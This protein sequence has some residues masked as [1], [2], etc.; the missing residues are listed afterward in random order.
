MDTLK[1]FTDA[2]KID[3]YKR[4]SNR[5][6]MVSVVGANSVQR[7]GDERLPKD[8]WLAILFEFVYFYVAHAEAGART[9]AGDE[10]AA[11]MIKGLGEPLIHGA[12][13]FVYD[14]VSKDGNRGLKSQHMGELVKRL[15][16]YRKCEHVMPEREGDESKGTALWAL[17]RNVAAL[18]NRPDDVTC[19]MTAHAHVFDSLT[20][21]DT[22]TFLMFT[23]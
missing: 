7:S 10:H 22:E 1:L 3:N 9:A 17:C 18:A 14:D 15:D 8:R 6:F 16:A 13:D 5:V 11:R 23:G 19:T 21:L 20:I 4:Y 2:D 12:V